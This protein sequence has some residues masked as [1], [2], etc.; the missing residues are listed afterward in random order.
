M[1]Q[2]IEKPTQSAIF[3]YITPLHDF[4]NINEQNILSHQ[5]ASLWQQ[6]DV[7]CLKDYSN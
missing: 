5:P 7:S 3:F 4:S 2:Y 6:Y 1:K